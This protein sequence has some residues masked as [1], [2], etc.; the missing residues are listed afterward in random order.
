MKEMHYAY[1]IS[2]EPTGLVCTQFE[3]EEGKMLDLLKDIQKLNTKG[4]YWIM[5]QFNG[6]PKTPL[7]IIDCEHNRIYYHHS[8]EVEGIEEMIQRLSSSTR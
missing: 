6:Q 5:K 7:C 8:G 1:K 4:M 2:N 3:F